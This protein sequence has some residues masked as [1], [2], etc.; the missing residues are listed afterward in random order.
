MKPEFIVYFIWALGVVGFATVIYGT[1]KHRSLKSALF[2]AKITRTVGE[3]DLGKR[4]IAHTVL[5]PHCLDPREPGAP[6][7]GIEVVTRTVASYSM[8]PIPLTTQQAA[9][10]R[11]MLVQAAGT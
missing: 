2:G 3:L 10:L 4:V 1:I 9:A 8:L 7:V 6:T 11:D 5:K